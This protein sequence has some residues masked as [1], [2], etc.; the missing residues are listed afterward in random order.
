VDASLRELGEGRGS[1]GRKRS[2]DSLSSRKLWSWPSARSC[3]LVGKLR[4]KG[5][6][7]L[8]PLKNIVQPGVVAHAFNPS[9]REAEAGGFLSSRPAWSTK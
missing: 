2:P 6:G 3:V 4:L 7:R 1:H 9:T 5:N 8:V